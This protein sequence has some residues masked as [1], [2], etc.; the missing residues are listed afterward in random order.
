MN[1]LSG[2]TCISNA[3]GKACNRAVDNIM[4]TDRL[5]ISSIIFANIE[6]DNRAASVMLVAPIANMARS[7]QMS[8][9]SIFNSFLM[10]FNRRIQKIRELSEVQQ[11]PNPIL[12]RS[13]PIFL[14]DSECLAPSVD[15][16]DTGN[17]LW[18]RVHSG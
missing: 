4:P 8:A 3:S 6:N 7:A 1:S 10:A 18:H 11:L 16:F 2:S 17:R 12:Y 13:L 15:L 5:I 9:E 14:F